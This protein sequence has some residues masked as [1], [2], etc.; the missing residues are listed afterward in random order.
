MLIQYFKRFIYVYVCVSIWHMYA[1]A[2]RGV[3]SP[4]AGD[5]DGCESHDMGAGN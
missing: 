3:G 5:R 1:G 4:V 2:F